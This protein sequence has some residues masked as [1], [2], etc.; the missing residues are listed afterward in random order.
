[1]ERGDER[2]RK[3]NMQSSANSISWYLDESSVTKWGTTDPKEDSL[4]AQHFKTAHMQSRLYLPNAEKD[5]MFECQRKIPL[6][7]TRLVIQ[8]SAC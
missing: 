5:Q 8:Q 7:H 3:K 1:M 6:L 4:K 2:K